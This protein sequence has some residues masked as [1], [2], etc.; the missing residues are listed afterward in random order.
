MLS[1]GMRACELGRTGGDH[2]EKTQFQSTVA[3]RC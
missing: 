3:Q 1:C 2:A